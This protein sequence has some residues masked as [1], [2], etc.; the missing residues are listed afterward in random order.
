MGA[1]CNRLELA[2]EDG[3]EERG[4]KSNSTTQSLSSSRKSFMGK[5]FHV[6]VGTTNK[7]KVAAVKKVMKEYDMLKNLIVKSKKVESGISD[8]PMTLD[9]TTRGAR[10]RA[11]AAFE[12]GGFCSFG[13]ESGLLKLQPDS[14]EYFDVC[15]VSCYDGKRFTEGL[16][17]AFQIP[18]KIMKYVLEGQNLTQAAN[19]AGITTK[20]D[21]GEREG[22]IGILSN[23]RIT[24]Q[25]YTE[26]GIRTAVFGIEKQDWYDPVEMEPEVEEAIVD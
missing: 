24:R 3:V 17:S 25:D 21:L 13:I 16:S 23:G 15:V 12:K 11:R 7:C 19:S 4:E 10:N 6:Y 18:Q 1:F 20:E 26:Q 14:S 2:D 5:C 9:E 8:Q 22:L